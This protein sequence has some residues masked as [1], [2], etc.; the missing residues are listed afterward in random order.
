MVVAILALPRNGR[1]F[2]ACVRRDA[3]AKAEAS[4]DAKG[5]LAAE[6]SATAILAESCAVF[7]SFSPKPFIKAALALSS[8]AFLAASV[9][10]VI[11]P[12]PALAQGFIC[13][14]S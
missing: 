4:Q 3:L 2:K 8:L 11:A 12:S 7:R 9:W 10:S 14:A 6:M 13:E 5:Q 1:D